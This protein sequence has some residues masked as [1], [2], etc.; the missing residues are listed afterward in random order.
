MSI[1]ENAR[2]T[3]IRRLEMVHDIFDSGL[4]IA[5]A[6]NLYGITPPTGRTWLNRFLAVVEA[7]LRDRSSQSGTRVSGSTTSVSR[8]SSSMDAPRQGSS[9]TAS[10]RHAPCT[11]RPGVASRMPRTEPEDRP[12]AA[13]TPLQ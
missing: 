4:A 8:S 13:A 9:S 3:F 2:L 7:G 10:S 12:Q 6:A 5:E 1:H 11:S